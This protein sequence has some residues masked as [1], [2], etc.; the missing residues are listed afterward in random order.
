MKKAALLAVSLAALLAGTSG[1]GGSQSGSGSLQ[2]GRTHS[3]Q[4]LQGAEHARGLSFGGGFSATQAIPGYD[5]VTL[6]NVPSNAQAVG[7]YASGAYVNCNEARA[8]FPHAHIISIA[9]TASFVPATCLDTEP[10]DSSPSEVAD[11]IRRDHA[12]GVARP[13]DYANASEMVSVRADV[14]AAGVPRSAWLEWVAAWDNNPAIP[15]GFD[16]HQWKSTWNL[17]WDTFSSAF[18]G[19]P[20][21]TGP[22]CFGSHRQHTALCDRV[23]T[24]DAERGRT[25]RRENGYIRVSQRNVATFTGRLAVERA[26][27]S[28]INTVLVIVHA[29]KQKDPLLGGLLA[30][31]QSEVKLTAASLARAQRN[32][33]A[34]QH[35][36]AVTQ[37]ALSASLKKYGF[38]G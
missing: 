21:P 4:F 12:A 14:A 2:G 8:R 33:K 9:T 1:C 18:F 38:R 6:S 16:A 34:E 5:A 22:V 19:P 35:K 30:R 29:A 31:Y 24:Q 36:A 32:L 17:D 25:V 23:R 20:K 3:A 26:R 37:A 7:C 10:G 13:C 15:A 28:A 11:W 27:V